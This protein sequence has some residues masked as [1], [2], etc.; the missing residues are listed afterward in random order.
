[1]RD[2]GLYTCGEGLIVCSEVVLRNSEQLNE[3]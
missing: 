2:V 3:E 1:M